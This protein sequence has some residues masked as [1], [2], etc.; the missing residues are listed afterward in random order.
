ME[1]Q[2]IAKKNL[3]GIDEGM[4]KNVVLLVVEKGREK[5]QNSIQVVDNLGREIEVFRIESFN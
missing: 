2:V 5:K 3:I 1:K 4:D